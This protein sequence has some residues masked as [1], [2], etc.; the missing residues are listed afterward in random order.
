MWSGMF[1]PDPG[2][3][4]ISIPDPPWS[5]IRGQKSTGSWIQETGKYYFRTRRILILITNCYYEVKVFCTVPC[6]FAL[7]KYRFLK[8]LPHSRAAPQTPHSCRT[9]WWR[10][11]WR[12]SSPARS[13]RRSSCCS[14]WRSRRPSTSRQSACSKK[15]NRKIS[16]EKRSEKIFR[17]MP[18]AWNKLF[19]SSM[20]R[21]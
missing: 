2:S 16:L 6:Y 15:K 19:F 4:F 18:C 11:R 12:A 9:Q 8:K 13:A 17:E 20:E 1:I 14:W 5:R 7:V 10:R 21:H 3:G